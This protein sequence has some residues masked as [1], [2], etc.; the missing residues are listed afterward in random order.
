[1]NTCRCQYCTTKPVTSCRKDS[2]LGLCKCSYC[3]PSYPTLGSN[4]KPNIKF[5]VET[6]MK[7][8]K[9]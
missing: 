5:M 3:K 4:T 1:M 6:N 7:I 2:A 8:F 9:N